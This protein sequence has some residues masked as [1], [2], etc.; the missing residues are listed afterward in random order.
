M[1]I[2][3]FRMTKGILI[4]VI[5]FLPLNLEFKF[6]FRSIGIDWLILY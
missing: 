4:R 3:L 6:H 1:D 2:I 5:H